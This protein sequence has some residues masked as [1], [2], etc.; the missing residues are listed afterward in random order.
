MTALQ[1]AL[2]AL[3]KERGALELE[4]DLLANAE[5]ELHNSPEYHFCLIRRG[6][7][8]LAAQDVQRAYADVCAAA[9][10]EYGASQNAR[11]AEGVQIKE[12]SKV[13]YEPAQA[14]GWCLAQAHK[15][16]Q[17]DTKAFEKAAPVL[18]DL[19]APVEL[20]KEPRVQIAT[21]LSVWLTNEGEAHGN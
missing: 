1:D 21:D 14:L 10:V 6:A 2:R 3:A 17:L 12:F 16:L 7:K 20:T 15:Y 13:V 18:K 9:L 19:G 11:P 8:D 4:C 5:T